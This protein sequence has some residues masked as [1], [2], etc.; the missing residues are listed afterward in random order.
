MLAGPASLECTS[1]VEWL[2][3]VRADQVWPAVTA[4]GPCRSAECGLGA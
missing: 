1:R 2:G 3:S 4:D